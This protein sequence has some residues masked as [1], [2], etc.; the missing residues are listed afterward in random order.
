MGGL[1]TYWVVDYKCVAWTQMKSHIGFLLGDID[2][3]KRFQNASI[4][5]WLVFL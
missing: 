5:I 1:P 2:I 3:Y 4:V